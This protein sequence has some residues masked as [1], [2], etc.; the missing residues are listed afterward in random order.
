MVKP[1]LT[2]FKRL[3]GLLYLKLVK[4]ND[5]P[6]KISLGFGV[7]VF[8]GIMPGTGPVVALFLAWILRANRLAALLGSL[9]TNTWLSVVIFMLSI[10]VGSG[11]L[12]LNW[13]DTYKGWTALSK[14]FHWPLLFKLSVS[15][16]ILT[17]IVG[18]VAVAFCIGMAVY[19]IALIAITRIRYAKNKGRINL[20]R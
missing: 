9:L 4:M 2:Q 8:S 5:T 20:S 14:D 18:Y 15:K 11:I 6:Q 10:K 1:D 12:R 17:V 7:G 13:Q 3:I 19:L 16:T